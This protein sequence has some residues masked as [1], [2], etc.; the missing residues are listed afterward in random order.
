MEIFRLLGTIAITNEEANNELDETTDKAEQT[1]ERIS[2]AFQKIGAAV[3]TYFAIEKIAAFGKTCLDAAANVQAMQSQFSQ[4]FGGYE[5]EAA[6]HLSTIA[7]D[8]GV[9]ENRLKGSYTQIAAFAK[10]TGMETEDALALADRALVAVADSA[11]FYDRSLEDVTE[12]LQSFLKGNYENDA[13]LGLSCTEITRNA[14]ANELYGQSFNDLSEAQKQL[15]LLKMVEDA[16]ALSGALGQAARESETWSNQTGN[17]Q[18]AWT[19]FT[20]MIGTGF[21]PIA[22]Q[23]V[24][25]LQELVT[26]MTE[27]EGVVTALAIGVGTLTTAIIAYNVAQTMATTGMTLA[28]AAGTALSA[29]IGFLTSPIT[30]VIAAIGA[31]VAAGVLLYKN[32]DTVKEKAIAFGEKV[33]QIWGGVSDWIENAIEKIGEHFLVFGGYLSGLWKSVEDVS[34]NVKGIFNGLIDFISNVFSG[35][36]SAA[37]ENVV[38]IF[39]N[40]F[41]GIVNIAKAPINGVIG[42]INSVLDKINNISVDIPDWMGGGTFGV[43]IPKIPMLAKGGVL[44]KGQVGL[45]EGTG[46]EAVVPLEHNRAWISAVAKDMDSTIGGGEQSQ[47]I[48]DLLEM[49]LDAMADYFPQLIEAAGHDIVANDGTILARYAPMMNA[50]LG[51]I[52]ARKERGR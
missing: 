43:N 41:G 20:A 49:M 21:L 19:D 8:A 15:T 11:A 17:L 25:K 7:D 36:W 22:I 44:E 32:W 39:G 3:T 30:L 2:N 37:W 14:A 34:E 9:V 31:L 48:I 33:E 50:E 52:S 46:A 35:N 38:S 42:M 45:L 13:A 27:H 26:W 18:Q 51:R 4:V 12:S 40:L 10:T 47:R 24:T 29:V 16:N 23:V 1:Q 28:T 6:A 5:D